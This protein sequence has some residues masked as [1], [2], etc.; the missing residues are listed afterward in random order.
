MISPLYALITGGSHGI[1]RAL[2]KECLSRNIPVLLV[3]LPDEDL[4]NTVAAFR[5]EFNLPVEAFGV[6]LCQSTSVDKVMEWI[7]RENFHIG[8]L[9]NNV[10]FGRS[11]LFDS[12]PLQEYQAMLRLNIEVATSLTYLL[13]PQLKRTSGSRILNVSSMEATLPLPYKAVYTGTKNYIYAFS[14]ALREELRG[15]SPT[16]TVLCPGPILTNEDGRKRLAAQ[17][18]RSRLLLMEP[19]EIAPAA[20]SAMLKGKQQLMP[21]TLVYLLVFIGRF[22]PT[23]IKMRI[24]ERLFRKYRAATEEISK[25]AVL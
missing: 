24:L 19:H 23:S 15:G 8:Y 11:G 1:G 12:I 18:R 21:G 14:L 10:G 16:V 2:A 7:E 17:G 25:P 13:L 9:I 5:S 20:I 22:L 4:K 3:A 6:D